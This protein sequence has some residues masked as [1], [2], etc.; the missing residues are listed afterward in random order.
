MSAPV[1]LQR[2]LLDDTPVIRLPAA[3]VPAIVARVLALAHGADDAGPTQRDLLE[4]TPVPKRD[5]EQ[6]VDRHHFRDLVFE[7]G[8][9]GWRLTELYYEE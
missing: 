9:R 7:Q 8:P 3:R 4:A 6:P 5:P 2:G 1:V